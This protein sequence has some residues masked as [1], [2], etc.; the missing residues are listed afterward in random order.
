MPVLRV[1][2]SINRYSLTYCHIRR[3]TQHIL[4]DNLQ[5]PAVG[6][7]GVASD[8]ECSILLLFMTCS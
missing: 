6:G 5:V 2:S 7:F 8:L 1:A 4:T 3:G